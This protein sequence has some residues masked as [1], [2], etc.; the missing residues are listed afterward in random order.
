MPDPHI[1][2]LGIG[3]YKPHF[4]DP[5]QFQLQKCLLPT[6]PSTPE[7]PFVIEHFLTLSLTK[8]LTKPLSSTRS[9]NTAYE[10]PEKELVRFHWV[11][12][13]PQLC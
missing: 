9:A 2:L 5:P 11:T 1:Q 4:N 3:H 10:R 13:T 12:H 8:P 6:S 7:S